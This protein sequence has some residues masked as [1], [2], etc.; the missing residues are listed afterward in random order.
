MATLYK[1]YSKDTKDL[2]TKN[3]SAAGDWK[4]ENKAKATKG[5]YAV[6]T[7]S[8]ARGDVTVDVEGLTAD[9][10]CYGKLSLTPKELHD[11]KASLRAENYRGNKVEAILTKKGAS[12]KDFSFEVNHETLQPLAN[13]RLRVN[14]KVTDK[15]VELGLSIA[16]VD[17]VQLGCG[18]TYNFKAQTCNWSAACRAAANKSTTVTLQTEALRNVEARVLTTAALHP[19][20]QPRVAANVSYDVSSKVWDGALGAEWGCSVIAGNTSKARV[21]RKLEWMVSYV[22]ALQGGWT[23]TLSLDKQMKAGV[24][25]VR[26]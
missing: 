15:A 17:G 22:A 21:N 14:D 13:G 5:N 10:A 16:A 12:L 24:S 8:N 25:L 18:A 9:G 3:F 20:F 26:N 19:R 1:D 23:L 7:A 2:L 6:G 11:I 4:I